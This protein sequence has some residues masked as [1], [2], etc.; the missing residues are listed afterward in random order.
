MEQLS[1][2]LNFPLCCRLPSSATQALW[3]SPA[4]RTM[5]Q[6]SVT[7]VGL[8]AEEKHLVTM[9]R[10]DAAEV[11]SQPGKAAHLHSH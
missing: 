8:M 5:P 4:M 9:H 7:R 2:R 11:A 3:S 6:A 1:G 10:K